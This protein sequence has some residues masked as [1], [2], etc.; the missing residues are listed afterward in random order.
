MAATHTQRNIHSSLPFYSQSRLGSNN[1]FSYPYSAM[2]AIASRRAQPR[3]HEHVPARKQIRTVCKKITTC[4]TV[5]FSTVQM[6]C[7]KICK[8]SFHRKGR[9]YYHFSVTDGTRAN[10]HGRFGRR[11]HGSHKKRVRPSY[12][13]GAY[14]KS[15]SRHLSS[16]L[17]NELL[18]D[19]SSD[20]V[21][22]SRRT[23]EPWSKFWSHKYLRLARLGFPTGLLTLCYKF[24]TL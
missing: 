24:L 3:A 8:V 19:D 17:S 4:E 21:H 23:A 20:N 11:K 13:S 14:G 15:N 5:R 6:T 1:N 7:N 10:L 22:Q 18:P 9:C 12:K 2:N 16:R